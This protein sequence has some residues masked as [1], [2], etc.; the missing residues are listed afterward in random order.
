MCLWSDAYFEAVRN[1]EFRRGNAHQ[2]VHQHHDHDGDEHSK[3]TDGGAH[4]HKTNQIKKRGSIF[5]CHIYCH[6]NFG[7]PQSYTE[8]IKIV[9]RVISLQSPNDG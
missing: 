8:T 1:V 2:I 7:E 6:N 9:S 4:L 3:V 5:Y